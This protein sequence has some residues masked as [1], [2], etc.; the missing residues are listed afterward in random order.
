MFVDC[1]VRLGTADGGPSGSARK[2]IDVNTSGEPPE[3][4]QGESK[5]VASAASC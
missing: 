1:K 3:Q 2:A 5:A 4:R